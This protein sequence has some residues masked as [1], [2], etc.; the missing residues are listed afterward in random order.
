MKDKIKEFLTRKNIIL[1]SIAIL[2]LVLT[3]LIVLRKD[4]VIEEFKEE[5]MEIEL[6]E[7]EEEEILPKEL[8]IIN[9]DSTSRPIAI[10][11]Q[12]S[13]TARPYHTGLQEAY[14]LYEM[15]VEG[16]IT[17]YLALYKDIDEDIE[18]GSVRSS[19]HYYL[20]YAMENDAIYVHWGWSDQA[21]EDITTYNINNINGLT[22]EGT[23]FYRKDIDL[24]SE[25]TGYTSLSL[26]NTAINKLNIRSE[27]NNNNLLNYSIEA[28]DNELLD[29]VV[30]ANDIDVKF[31]SSNIVNFD[32][33]E[34]NE[35]YRKSINNTPHIDY[36][37][38]DQYTFKNIIVYN[39]NNYSMDSYG[40]QELENIGSGTGYFISNGE[41]VQIKWSKSSRS[42]QT[43]YTYM[44][45]SSLEVNDGN[46][47]IG[48]APIEYSV[49][50]K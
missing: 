2:I 18:I 46:T 26:I 4:E 42:S 13:S 10:M 3:L 35:V 29:N 28:I 44:D 25:H 41:A 40:R 15:V 17:R 47:Y 30:T 38:G 20:D 50:I 32:Y 21:K 27:M 48:I 5:I 7:E 49:S 1:I 8:Q 34:E 9:A 37:S 24:S 45:G 39:V 16:G 22:Y 11:V 33:D 23:Y 12:N 19:R 14:I 43:V 6:I 31:S 36:N